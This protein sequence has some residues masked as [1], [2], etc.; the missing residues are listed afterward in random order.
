MV[1]PTLR[2]TV[3]NNVDSAVERRAGIE[4]VQPGVRKLGRK[5]WGETKPNQNKI[6]KKDGATPTTDNC[7]GAKFV[8]LYRLGKLYR[9]KNFVTM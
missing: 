6:K 2:L 7:A 1:V 5:I 9:I 3:R 8:Y 4:K